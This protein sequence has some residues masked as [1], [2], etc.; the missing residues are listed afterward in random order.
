[1]KNMVSAITP[2]NAKL[3]SKGVKSVRQHIS[4]LK[5][6]IGDKMNITQF[7]D[8][9]CKFM[10]DSE[11]ILSEKE[12]RDIEEIPRLGVSEKY[13]EL[14]T[15][16]IHSLDEIEINRDLYVELFSSWYRQNNTARQ[17]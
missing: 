11:Y 14:Y 5:D 7:K 2:S 15:T 1:M 3:I 6:Y 13:K 8:Y 9:T 17:I 16:P 12:V 10:C 4:L